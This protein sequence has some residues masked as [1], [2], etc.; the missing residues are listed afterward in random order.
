MRVAE[1]LAQAHFSAATGQKWQD[2]GLTQSG[3]RHA[4]R[5]SFCP[6]PCPRVHAYPPGN[7]GGVTLC[8]GGRR[9]THNI[10]ASIRPLTSHQ[11]QIV[12][13]TQYWRNFANDR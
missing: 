1:D 8:D 10:R 6:F 2:F 11:C 5:G 3:Y 7:N 4:I 13:E 9:K 12:L